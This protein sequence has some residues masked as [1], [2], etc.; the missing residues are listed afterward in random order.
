MSQSLGGSVA[1]GD[2]GDVVNWKI[3]ANCLMADPN[4]FFP[5]VGSVGQARAVINHFC[6]PCP[7]RLECLNA[8]IGERYG[9]WGGTTPKERR[10]IRVNQNLLR[11]VRSE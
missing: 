7:V 9:I 2:R 5:E 1:H 8:G 3:K 4:Q 11:N 10:R 6:K